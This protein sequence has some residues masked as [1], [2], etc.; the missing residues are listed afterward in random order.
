MDYTYLLPRLVVGS[1]MKTII[2][3]TIAFI[4]AYLCWQCNKY[5]NTVTRVIYSILAFVL[6]IPYLIYYFVYHYLM[7]RSCFYAN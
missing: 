6:Y 1:I 4:A 3:I 7:G 5:E 2:V